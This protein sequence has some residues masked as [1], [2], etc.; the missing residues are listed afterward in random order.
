M[1]TKEAF[2]DSLKKE[3]AAIKCENPDQWRVVYDEVIGKYPDWENNDIFDYNPH[4][5][6]F[7][8]W[9]DRVT[10]YNGTTNEHPER[11]TFT[12]FVMIINETEEYE[13]D[14]EEMGDLL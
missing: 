11:L 13:D 5:P 10:G 7:V 8:K 1:M 14:I 4:Y 2:F 12:E 3:R 9:A 6:Y